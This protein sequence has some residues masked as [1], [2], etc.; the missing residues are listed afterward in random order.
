MR[1]PRGSTS[2]PRAGWGFLAYVLRCLRS[3]TGGNPTPQR[4]R[5]RRAGALGALLV[6]ALHLGPAARARAH[7]SDPWFARDKALH[8]GASFTLALGGYALGGQLTPREPPRLAAGALLSLSLGVGKE[9]ADR[10]TGGHPSWRDLGWDVLGTASGLT[11][12]WLLDRY[13]F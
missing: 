3:T 6:A 10:Y 12:A 9:I 2:R 8:Y 4:A 5:R 11:V 7:V 13:V 1:A